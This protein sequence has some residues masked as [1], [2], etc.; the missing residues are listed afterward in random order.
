MRELADKNTFDAIVKLFNIFGY[1]GIE[2]DFQVLLRFT[3]ASA[4]VAGC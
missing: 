2:Y 4:P 1:F 3:D